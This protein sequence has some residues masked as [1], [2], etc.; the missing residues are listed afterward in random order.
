M[1]GEPDNVGGPYNLPVSGP[2]TERPRLPLRWRVGVVTD[3]EETTYHETVPGTPDGYYFDEV[4]PSTLAGF[5]GSATQ[6]MDGDLITQWALPYCDGAGTP[7]AELPVGSYFEFVEV[8]DGVYWVMRPLPRCDDVWIEIN[9]DGEIAHRQQPTAAMLNGDYMT[10]TVS[11]TAR[12]G[13]VDYSCCYV[14][15]DSKGHVRQ[16]ADSTPTWYAWPEA[17]P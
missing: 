1:S 3:L 12:I 16:Y 6:D 2:G 17:H 13:G 5:R 8:T 11:G 4:D 14:R 10:L 9:T 15:V 7:F